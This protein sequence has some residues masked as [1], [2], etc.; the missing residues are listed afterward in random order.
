MLPSRAVGNINFLNE[1]GKNNPKKVIEVTDIDFF[2]YK[3]VIKSLLFFL[4]N[5]LTHW[6]MRVAQWCMKLKKFEFRIIRSVKHAHQRLLS[7]W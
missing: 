7:G 3:N 6:M 4:K 5:S 1:K 2:V